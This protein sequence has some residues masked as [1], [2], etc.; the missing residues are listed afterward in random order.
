MSLINFDP[1]EI[2][3]YKLVPEQGWYKGIVRKVG[4][5][6]PSKT[7]GSNAIVFDCEAELLDEKVDGTCIMFWLNDKMQETAATFHAAANGMTLDEFLAEGAGE[8]DLE[9]D[10]ECEMYFEVM[11]RKNPNNGNLG[12]SIEN[13][14]PLKANKS[15]DVPFGA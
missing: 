2:S 11:H 9:E 15:N 14:A 7:E 10:V 1:K 4:A 3:K 8:V 5:G 6:R 13:F 12:N